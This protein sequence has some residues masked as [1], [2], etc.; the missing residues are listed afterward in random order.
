MSDG[1]QKRLQNVIYILTLLKTALVKTYQLFVHLQYEDIVNQ[2][3][4]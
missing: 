4:H 3:G 2:S 1:A